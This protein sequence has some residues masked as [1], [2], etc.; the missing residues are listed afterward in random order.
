[1]LGISKISRNR[2]AVTLGLLVLYALCND[3]SDQRLLFDHTG[4]ATL[5]DIRPIHGIAL[6]SESL[7]GRHS[8]QAKT[9][10]SFVA[11]IPG[12]FRFELPVPALSEAALFPNGVVHS[13]SFATI[14]NTRAPPNSLKPLHII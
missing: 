12:D 5:T 4:S 14:T 3:L 9:R 7:R 6:T 8:W 10:D 11:A 1:M 13:D 2:V